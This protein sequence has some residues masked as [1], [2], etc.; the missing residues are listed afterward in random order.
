M[1]N[2]SWREDDLAEDVAGSHRREPVAGLAQRAGRGRSPGGCRWSTSSCG[3]TSELVAGAHR[4]AD[5]VELEEE[6][7]LQVGRRVRRRW[8][9]PRRRSCRR[10]AARAASASRSPRRRS[11]SRRRR[12][13]AAARRSRTPR[14]RRAPWRARRAPR[15]GW[16]PTRAGRR[17]ERAR[18]RRWP[19]R[20]PRPGSGRSGRAAAPDLT[21]SIR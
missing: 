3:E 6:H 8:W 15:R 7:P 14:A 19:R 16:S 1:A 11:R 13:R 9:S 4:R 21:N 12:A 18:S 5:D 20:R 17:G 2:W 10:A